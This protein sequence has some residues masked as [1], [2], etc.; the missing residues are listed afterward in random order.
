VS[1]LDSSSHE[2]R[3]T[4]TLQRLFRGIKITDCGMAKELVISEMYLKVR[5]INS[6][7]GG[8]FCTSAASGA[9]PGRHRMMVGVISRCT[10]PLMKLDLPLV[11]LFLVLYHG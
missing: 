6:T 4:Q 3:L 1:R 8:G 11:F 5:M 9:T 7:F 10:K 2:R